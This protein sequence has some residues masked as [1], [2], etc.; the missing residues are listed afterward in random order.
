VR[1][2]LFAILESHGADF[3]LVLDLY[4]G[5]GA[6][7]QRLPAGGREFIIDAPPARHPAESRQTGCGNMSSLRRGQGAIPLAGPTRW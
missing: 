4:S 5:T 3:A 1:E 6:M 7:G 2:A